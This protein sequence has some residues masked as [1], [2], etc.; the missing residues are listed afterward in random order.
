M[1]NHDAKDAC[2]DGMPTARDDDIH[3]V[4][5]TDCHLGPE[6]DYSLAGVRTLHSFDEVLERVVAATPQPDLLLVTGDIAAHGSR[7]AY[8][9][10]AG[11]LEASG[12]PWVWLPGNHDDMQLLATLP[13][14]PAYRR[15]LKL[16]D[17]WLLCLNTAVP[18]SVGGALS[19][20]EMDFLE[21]ALAEAGTGPVALFMHHPPD[22][23]GCRWLDRQQVV[24]GRELSELVAASG[25]V[26]A[27]FTG[28]V[29][30]AAT[31]SFAGASLYATPSTCFQFAPGREDFA[32]D[33]LPPAFRRIRL[34]TDG[35]LDTA[36]CWIEDTAETVDTG[37]S[38]Y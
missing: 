34:G 38:G 18:G 16:G 7:A 14:M 15:R 6:P 10:F 21:H 12:L 23:V 25:N 4:Q 2:G 9:L 11:R 19:R 22:D 32:L 33:T 20:A 24:N 36:L 3:L 1:D 27:I 8:E 28:H 31:Q 30:Q 5:L 17:W 35:T 26:R 29:H 13:S 37:A